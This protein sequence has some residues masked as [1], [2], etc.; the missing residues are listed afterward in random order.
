MRR[1]L[2][3]LPRTVWLLGFI[4]LLNDAA[5]D[6]IYPLVPLYIA[7]VLMAGPKA[8]GWIEGVAEAAG[9][10]LKLI[11]GV[12]ADRMRRIKP[13][14]V[15]GYGLAGIARPLI[16]LATSWVGVLIFRFVDRVGKGLRSAPRDALLASSVAP[17]QRGL[18]YGLHRGM[19][20]AGAVIGPL[21]AAALLASGVSLRHVFLL[22]IVPAVFVLLLALRLRE[23]EHPPRKEALRV[24]WRFSALSPA[25][26]RYLAALGL[27]T[28]GNASNM[29]L[30]LRANELGFDAAHTTLLWAAFSAVASLAATPLS[31]WSDRIGRKRLILAGWGGYAVLYIIFGVLPIT[32][33]VL[34]IAFPLYGLVT[35]A[36]EGSERALV[37][38]LVPAERAGTA[39]GWYYLVTGLLLLPASAIFGTLWQHGSPLLAFAASAGCAVAAMA[40]LAPKFTNTGDARA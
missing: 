28:L 25:Y 35:A 39:F 20:N 10:L 37:A 1:A 12:L 40:V 19:D 15:I 18:A 2:A 4:S 31:A 34:W 32:A 9:S 23:P 11:A 27:F 6:M 16:G 24:D 26:R 29:F 38:D 3:S 7:S 33:G 14:V 21:I 17:E 5:S 22:A 8:L 30:L 36:I 13:F